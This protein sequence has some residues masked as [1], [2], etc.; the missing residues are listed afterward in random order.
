MDK[1]KE[2]MVDQVAQCCARLEKIRKLG[3][4]LALSGNGETASTTRLAQQRNRAIAALQHGCPYTLLMEVAHDAWRGPYRPLRLCEICG[5][6][7]STWHFERLT[8]GRIRP[9]S[10]ADCRRVYLDLL[11]LPVP[12]VLD[13]PPAT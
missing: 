8:S 13:D 6:I 12:D 9:G 2:L 10:Q 1:N 4:Q 11:G 7:E 5:L 3:Q